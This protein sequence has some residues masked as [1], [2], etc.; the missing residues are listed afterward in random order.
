MAAWVRGSG[1]HLAEH[2]QTLE[3]QWLPTEGRERGEAWRVWP[4]AQC[5]LQTAPHELDSRA[6]A[7]P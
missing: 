2:C 7:L 6:P 4:G 1:W 5:R 3:A